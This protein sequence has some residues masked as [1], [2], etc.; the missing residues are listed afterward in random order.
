MIVKDLDVLIVGGGGILYDFDAK[1]YLREA[2]IA[3]EKS[4]PTM[5]Y[6]V[7]AGPLN[8]PESQKLVRRFSIM[9]LLSLSETSHHSGCLRILGFLGR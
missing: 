3:Y 6:A 4:V 1:I 9:L 8:D 7:G 5:F 2:Q